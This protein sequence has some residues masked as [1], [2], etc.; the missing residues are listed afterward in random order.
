MIDPVIHTKLPQNVD[1]HNGEYELG[2]TLSTFIGQ[3]LEFWFDLNFLPNVP[4]IDLMV[5]SKRVGIFVCE[6]KS[7]T[8]QQIGH[9]SAT[10]FIRYDGAPQSHPVKQ[11]RRTSQQLKTFHS[12]MIKEDSSTAAVPFFQT[13]VIWSRITRAQWNQ[14]FTSPALRAQAKSF[15]FQDDL[16]NARMFIEKL[17]EFSKLPL[18]GI[19]PPINR[20]KERSGVTSLTTYINSAQQ[21]QKRSIKAI[22]DKPAD[23]AYLEKELKKYPF[24]EK[25]SV[26]MAGPAGTGKTTFLLQLGMQHARDGGSVLYL[27]YNRALA[28]EVQQQVQQMRHEEVMLGHIDIYDQFALYENLAP[29][30]KHLG[31][32]ATAAD[33]ILCLKQLPMDEVVKYD[34]ILIDEGQDIDGN[35]VTL[36]EY[37]STEKTSWFASVSKGQE[38]Y[39][40]ETEREYPCSELQKVM[41]DAKKPTRNRLFRGG[42]IPFLASFAFQK[43]APNFDK[44]QK[45]I[46]EKVLTSRFH[47]GE[48]DRQNELPTQAKS[49]TLSY[50]PGDPVNFQK[51]V[52]TAVIEALQDVKNTEGSA[53]LLIVV[54]GERSPTYPIVKAALREAKVRIHDLTQEDNRRIVA[55]AGSVRIVKAMGSR[56]L[57]ASH[58]LVFDFDYIQNWCEEKPGRAPAVNLG[59]VVLTRSH[60]STKVFV[61]VDNINET[62]AFLGDTLTA[63]R[64]AKL[65]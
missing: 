61:N 13:T 47:V 31:H 35:A 6:V 27:C 21:E 16:L 38:L 56:G 48:D 45:F 49:L 39:G 30:I 52:R 9:Y 60:N 63:L 22:S 1:G 33:V 64:I 26:I 65:N 2:Q 34:T 42:E 15:V 44:V 28:T 62:V 46:D 12:R 14:R 57:S 55:P 43:F 5:F 58:V 24:G 37:L 23:V 4:D 11:V 41:Q 53:D 10:D 3:G 25:H 20:S 40:F 36:A 19:Y 32:E 18:L 17:S 51:A 59:Y 8:I 7:H 54:F 50:L 29:E